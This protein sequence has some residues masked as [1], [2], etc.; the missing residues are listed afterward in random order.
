MAAADGL[1]M[2]FDA[3][4]ADGRL[5]EADECRVL[6]ER[7]EDWV[8]LRGADAELVSAKHPGLS[9]GAYTT[10][11]SLADD[12]GLAHLFDRWLAM[13]EKATC[14]LVTTAGLDGPPK[15]LG[16]VAEKL[17]DRRLAGQELISD[18]EFDEQLT[19][20]GKALLKHCDG[21]SSR[22]NPGPGEPSD[23][24]PAAEHLSQIARFL[25]MLQFQPSI[26]KDYVVFAAPGMYAQ[27]VLDRLGSSAAADAVWE[28]VVSLFRARM[29]A[30]GPTPT[31]G[32]PSVLAYTLGASSP[33]PVDLEGELG[34]RIV[35][36]TDIDL[37]VRTAIAF[38]QGFAR[39]PRMVRTSLCGSQI[40]FGGCDV[41]VC[42]WPGYR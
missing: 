8:A 14:R 22:W 1:R 34:N 42:P 17:R 23:G 10:M 33:T 2:Y 35:T 4:D 5:V 21:L 28:A 32:L 11:N 19:A 18:G 24:V 12:G 27:P 20:F 29:R 13:Q 38:P 25:S 40:R 26:R 9:F 36:L 3:L 16:A 15:Q 31:G 41:R 30:A 39:L 6:C 7:H 37:A